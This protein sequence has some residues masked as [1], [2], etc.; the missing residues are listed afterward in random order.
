MQPRDLINVLLDEAAE[1][2]DRDDAAMDLGG[3]DEPAAEEA[4]MSV[5][6]NPQSDDDLVETCAEA[7]CEIWL[8]RGKAIEKDRWERLPPSAQRFASAMIRTNNPSLLP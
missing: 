2:G 4:L 3:Y 5:A 7:L 1:Y 6:A 8:R